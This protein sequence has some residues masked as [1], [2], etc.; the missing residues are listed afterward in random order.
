ML[1]SRDIFVEIRGINVQMR[2]S[3]GC[4]QGGVLSPLLWNMVVDDLLNRL[5]KCLVFVQGYADDVVIISTG[6][7]PDSI[8]NKM[9]IALNCVQ[10]WCRKTGLSVN[11]NKTS[12]VGLTAPR[13]FQTRLQLTDQVKYLGITL[14]S[15]LNWNTHIS[16]RIIKASIAY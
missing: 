13:L 7:H 14:D 11:A 5:S 16:N 1:K 4:P 12:N 3:R 6:S 10:N 9:Q 8:S 2:V 15:K